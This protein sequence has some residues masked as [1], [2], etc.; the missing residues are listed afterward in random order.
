MRQLCN[1]EPLNATAPHH[2]IHLLRSA[3]VQMLQEQSDR[4][5]VDTTG[6][7]NLIDVHIEFNKELAGPDVGG[8]GVVESPATTP[9]ELGASLF[10]AIQEIGLKLKPG[11][12]LEEVLVVDSVQ[13]TLAELTPGIQPDCRA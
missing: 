3:S 8:A 4:I 13:T 6:I 10:N 2:P 1:P 5:I 7:D 12:A 11:R 9:N